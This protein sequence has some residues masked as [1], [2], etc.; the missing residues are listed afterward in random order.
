VSYPLDRLT[1]EV[2]YVAYHFHWSM[3]DILEMEHQERHM[4]IREISE[5]NRKINESSKPQ[6][7]GL[8]R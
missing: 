8:F 7:G 5:I 2:A 6:S 1:G 4:W 3:D